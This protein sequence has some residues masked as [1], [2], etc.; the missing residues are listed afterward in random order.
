MVIH[1][2][3]GG[4]KMSKK[5]RVLLS[6]SLALFVVAGVCLLSSKV[7]LSYLGNGVSAVR[8][9]SPLEVARLLSG[10]YVAAV[11]DIVLAVGYR[12]K[13]ARAISV[14]ATVLLVISLL[15]HVAICAWNVSQ[16]V[17]EEPFL[18]ALILALAGIIVSLCALGCAFSTEAGSARSVSF[19]KNPE[20]QVGIEKLEREV[21][22]LQSEVQ[23]LRKEIDELKDKVAE[24]R[25][26]HE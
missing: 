24:G 25:E 10:M 26:C 1:M 20:N 7:G 2:R 22:D 23:R 19:D 6:I 8:P 17:Y 4:T 14:V 12:T 9:L 5:M 18:L 13:H 16:L 3:L 21:R 15:I 11:A